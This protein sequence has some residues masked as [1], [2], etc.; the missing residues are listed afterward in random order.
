VTQSGRGSPFVTSID[1]TNNVIVWV[2]GA[3]GDQR[4]HGYDGDT[5]AVIFA[6]GGANELMTGTRRFS[7]G[8]V[9]RGAST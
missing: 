1:G 4:L 9:A 2:V 8:I 3:E 7:T 6:G 5:G